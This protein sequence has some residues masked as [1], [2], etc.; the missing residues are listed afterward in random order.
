[1][2]SG[3]EFDK[4]F[5]GGRTNLNLAALKSYHAWSRPYNCSPG[6]DVV[7]WHEIVTAELNS[8]RDRC[9]QDSILDALY[10]TAVAA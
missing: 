6:L 1:V 10:A 5:A 9:G 8:Y 4:R 7:K 2:N 3:Q